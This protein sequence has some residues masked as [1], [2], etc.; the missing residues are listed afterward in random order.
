MNLSELY[1]KGG[2]KN[3]RKSPKSSAKLHRV[4]TYKKGIDNKMWKVIKTKNGVKRWKKIKEYNLLMK[5]KKYLKKKI[6]QNLTEYKKG[7]Y[8][9]NKQAIAV[10]YSQTLKKY[11]NCKKILKN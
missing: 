2:K 4:G 3:K 11:P 1:Y 9:N 5:C 8:K 10:A 7:R 6:N